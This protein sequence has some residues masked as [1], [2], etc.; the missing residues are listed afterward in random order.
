MSIKKEIERAVKKISLSN[1]KT[2][3]ELKDIISNTL[4]SYNN[5]S[6]NFAKLISL[7]VKQ[8]L[9]KR[10]V[11]KY[12]DC[13][14]PENVLCQC[15]KQILDRTFEIKYPNRNKISHDLFTTLSAITQMTDFTIFK[16]DF[17]DFFNSVSSIYTF[18]KYLKKSNLKYY[19][20]D[21]IK[22]YVYST[23]YAFAGLCSS[24]TIVEIIAKNF[25]KLLCQEFS[26]HGIIFYERYIDDCILILNEDMKEEKIKETLKNILIEI[27]H[28][29]SIENHQCKTEFNEKKFQYI[30]K[31]KVL[32]EKC[33]V[34]FLG[35][36]FYFELIEKQIIIKY[37]ITLEKRKKYEKRLN[38]LILYCKSLSLPEHDETELLRHMIR[39]FS[40]RSVYIT[41]Y[42]Q[43]SIWRVKGFISNYG[44]LRY[45]LD[46][47][48]IEPETKEFLQNAIDNAFNAVKFQP[49]FL[50]ANKEKTECGYNLYGNM[51]SNKTI[52]LV[53]HI[54]Y[55]YRSLVTLCKQVRINILDAKGKKKKYGNLVKEYL[56]K[57]KVGY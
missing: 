55:D 24:N 48:L 35:Y 57:I 6:F 36:E 23:K 10:L 46:T 27:F 28:D 25:D 29:Q 42:Y 32:K 51:K 54:G 40:S 49:Y 53:K 26:S 37:G 45:L 21:L 47:E 1:S 9:K 52:L 12:D 41:K 16:F 56:I 8:N 38:N 5:S 30:S 44:E 3:T 14:S 11:K 13:Y 18:E 19:E 39:A 17:K 4:I 22:D 2:S 20:N 31:K 43:S 34:D 15:I 7:I 50:T 33:S